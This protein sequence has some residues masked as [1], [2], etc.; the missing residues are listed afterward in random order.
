MHQARGIVKVYSGIF[1]FFLNTTVV[2]NMLWN[3]SFA[4][5]NS[6]RNTKHG[7]GGY[8]R[9]L[10]EILQRCSPAALL[11]TLGGSV[12][13]MTKLVVSDL[14]TTWPSI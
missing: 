4:C 13:F 1:H 6:G 8:Y 5:M 10:P 11:G 2:I 7:L 12:A 9:L 14:R 3:K